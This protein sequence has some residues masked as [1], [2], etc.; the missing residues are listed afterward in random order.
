MNDRIVHLCTIGYI[1][2]IGGIATKPR[3]IS[4]LL[5]TTTTYLLIYLAG[6]LLTLTKTTYSYART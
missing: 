2:L 6:L 4:R 5:C 1:T 3:I